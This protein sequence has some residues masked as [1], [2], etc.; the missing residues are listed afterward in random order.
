MSV[1]RGKRLGIVGAGN[2]GQALL[3]GLRAAG[4]P[5][6]ALLVSERDRRRCAQVRQR[7]GV[8]CVALEALLRRASV[9]LV[10]VKPQDIRDVLRQIGAA[11]R[12]RNVLVISI[13]AGIPIRAMARLAGRGPVVRVMPNLPATIGSGISALAWGRG[14]S[15]ADRAVARA[16]FQGVGEV[17]VV[18]ERLLDAVTAISGS[19]PAYFFAVFQA[20]REAG[21][22]RGLPGEVAERLAVC[23]ALGSAKLALEAPGRLPGLIARVASKKGTTEAALKVFRRR[24]LAAV[25]EAGVRA[26]AQRS[27]ELTALLETRVGG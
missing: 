7:F 16:I 9:V 13:A 26:A 3:G 19:G 20:L 18:P 25:I 2:M 1:L 21:V 24:R 8:G 5:A 17:I 27:K 22:R 15:A 23:T 11:R 6:G 4:V 12:H 10:A 14:V